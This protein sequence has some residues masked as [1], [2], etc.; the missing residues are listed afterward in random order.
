MK[1]DYKKSVLVNAAKFSVHTI[2]TIGIQFMQKKTSWIFATICNMALKQNKLAEKITDI[3]Y[4][5][6]NFLFGICT[7][8]CNICKLTWRRIIQ[9]GQKN[10]IMH[11][12]T[13]S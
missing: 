12:D 10:V 3:K 2:L 13:S 1:L 9:D 8:N 6:R 7:E 5:T 11:F 4:F